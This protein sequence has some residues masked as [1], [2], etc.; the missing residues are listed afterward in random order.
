MT[1]AAVVLD[2]ALLGDRVALEPPRAAH[3]ADA[4]AGRED[5]HVEH[6]VLG[7][8]GADAEPPPNAPVTA[9]ITCHASPSNTVSPSA[10]TVHRSGAAV[11]PRGARRRA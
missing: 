11:A 2:A 1:I 4:G 6:A 7:V 8:R 9:T 10:R 3:E 5:G